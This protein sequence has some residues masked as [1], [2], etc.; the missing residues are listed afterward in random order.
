MVL[1][2][3]RR[4]FVENTRSFLQSSRLFYNSLHDSGLELHENLTKGSV[5]DAGS[6]VDRQTEERRT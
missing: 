4:R 1:V 6:E 5:T 3:R 2:S